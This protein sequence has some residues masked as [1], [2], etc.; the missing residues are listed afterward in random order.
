MSQD[1]FSPG[2]RLSHR[3]KLC[4]VRYVGAVNGKD[5]IWLGVEWDDPSRGK[6]AG[7][8]EGKTYFSCT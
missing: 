1:G 5:G 6:H 7:T 2:Q 4:T 8:F 3:S